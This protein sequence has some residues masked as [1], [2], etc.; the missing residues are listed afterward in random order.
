MND[1]E[2][3]NQK[4]LFF[5]EN[6]LLDLIRLYK[7]DIYP[8]KL[9]LSGLKGI[10]KSTLAYHFINYVLSEDDDFKYDVSN[11]KI[12]PESSTFKTI[13]NKSNTNLI[14]I[15]F[16]SDKKLIDIN[17]IRELIISLNKTS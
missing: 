11:Y 15:D 5:L 14:T 12:N 16:D 6:H 13:L 9:L 2:P 8:N 4:K 3:I 7:A 17:Q 10:G 1:L